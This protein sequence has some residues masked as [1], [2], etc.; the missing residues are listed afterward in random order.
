ML[1]LIHISPRWIFDQHGGSIFKKQQQPLQEQPKIFTDPPHT[2]NEVKHNFKGRACREIHIKIA[3]KICTP[4]V[5]IYLP[6]AYY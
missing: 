6:Q 2:E 4:K 1:A 3:I 5:Y